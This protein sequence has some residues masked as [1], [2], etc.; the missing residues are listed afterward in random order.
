MHHVPS[1]MVLLSIPKV[2][3]A[4]R[5]IARLPMVC[6]VWLHEVLVTPK[7]CVQLLMVLL[8][9]LV[10]VLAARVIARLQLVCFVRR[11]QIL[12]TSMDGR[13]KCT[14]KRRVGGVLIWLV[15]VR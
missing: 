7:S 12:A 4:A 8:S 9:I 1:K 13:R 3:R 14:K 10:I 11:Q 6:F 15:G 2:V 5:V